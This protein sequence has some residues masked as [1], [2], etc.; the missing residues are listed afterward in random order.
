MWQDYPKEIPVMT[1]I[2]EVLVTVTQ[3]DHI[4]IDCNDCGR[5]AIISGKPIRFSLH[6]YQTNTCWTHIG[7]NKQSSLYARKVDMPYGKDEASDVQKAKIVAAIVLS[8]HNWI[9]DNQHLFQTAQ[10]AH[11]N[12]RCEQL[13]EKKAEL[14]REMTAIDDEIISLKATLA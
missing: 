10:V 9:S 5:H 6:Y 8:L 7:P 2:G 11:V 3:A 13:E 12:N 1:S 4:Y 14:L